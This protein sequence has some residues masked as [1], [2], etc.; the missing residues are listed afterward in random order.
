MHKVRCTGYYVQGTTSMG[1][2]RSS[3]YLD[4]LINEINKL[5]NFRTRTEIDRIDRQQADQRPVTSSRLSSLV[6]VHLM[7]VAIAESDWNY[8]EYCG[9]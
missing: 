3:S 9:C 4:L 8:V 2:M 7:A 1:S 5:V 6:N